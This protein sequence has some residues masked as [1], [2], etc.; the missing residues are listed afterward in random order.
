MQVEDAVE[1]PEID[2][3]PWR[4]NWRGIAWKLCVFSLLVVAFATWIAR[5][6]AKPDPHI[7]DVLP[8]GVKVVYSPGYRV[9]LYGLERL[10]PF[11]TFKYDK[12]ARRLLRDDLVPQ[13][14]F[15]IP[16]PA[17]QEQLEAVHDPSYLAGLRDAAAV[18]AVVEVGVPGF[19]S[20][21]ALDQRVIHPFRLATGG[22]TAAVAAALEHGTGI[23]L[24]GGFHHAKPE[25]GHGFCMFNDVAVALYVARQRGFTG[26]VLVVDTDAHQGDGNHA[27]FRDDSLVYTL[28]L[29]QKKI[30]PQ[31]RIAGDRDVELPSGTDDERYLATLAEVI[32]EA[33]TAAE[34]RLVVHVAGSD[35][36]D[37]D[38]LATLA[39]T[40]SGLIERDLFVAHSAWERG[41]PYVHLLAG[42]YGPSSAAAQGDAVAA[43][44]MAAAERDE[45]YES[46]RPTALE[47]TQ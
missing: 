12:I 26:R 30:F 6:P 13:D 29:H 24:G 43:V 23:N 36:L 33:Y 32:E 5:P 40:P 17:S 20:P 41:I 18:A 15:E 38:P 28:S 25:G 3:T 8:G 27:A 16:G 46:T 21:S 31:P 2:P 19:V 42:G 39:L 9:G 4:T 22:T 1:S 37:D 7:G 10:H 34:P 45:Q 11:D 47:P 14:A 35:V 44:L